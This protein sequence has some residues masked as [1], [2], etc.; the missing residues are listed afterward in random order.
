MRKTIVALV[1]AF[2]LPLATPARAS[3][4]DCDS[5][6]MPALGIVEVWGFYVDDRNYVFGNGVWIYEESNGI[7]TPRPP[8]VYFGDPNHEWLQRGSPSDPVPTGQELCTDDPE[9][10]H[11]H[12]II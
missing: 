12:L 10:P 4:G 6:G 2:V 11:D 5:K 9:V 8:G 7:Y 1:L 3:I